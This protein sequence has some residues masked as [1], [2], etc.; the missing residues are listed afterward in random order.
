MLRLHSWEVPTN[1]PPGE[2][3][4]R[5]ESQRRQSEGQSSQHS[6]EAPREAQEP[7]GAENSDMSEAGLELAELLLQ[8]RTEGRLTA[9]DTCLIGYWASQAG[10]QGPVKELGLGPGRPTGHYQRHLDRKCGMRGQAED[11]YQIAVPAH[12]KHN[13]ERTVINV[14]VAPP[15]E[16]L[17]REYTEDPDL[18]AKAKDI[19]WPPSVLEHK[20]FKG[21]GGT[22]VPLALYVDAAEYSTQ[23]S[24]LLFVI[25]NLVS[26]ARHLACVVKKKD[27]CRCGCR[28]WCSLK[29]IMDLLNWSFSALARGMFP[30]SR[31]DG[32]PW[33]PEEEHRQS[34]ANL[35][36]SLVGAVAQVKGDWAEFSHTFGFPSWKHSEYP[37]LFCRADRDSMYAFDNLDEPGLP[38]DTIGMEEYEV[39]CRRCERHVVIRSEEQRAR[40]VEQLYYDKRAAG[41]RG[42]S[43]KAG[44][45]ELQLKAGDRLEPNTTLCD[46]ADFEQLP[47]P[48][49]VLFWRPTLETVTR[50]RNPL[51]NRDTGV[52]PESLKVDPLHCLYLGVFQIHISKVVWA[53]LD[54]DGWRVGALDDSWTE[55]ERSQMACVRMQA[56]L[57]VWCKDRRRSH[58]DEVITEV[59]EITPKMIGSRA[60]QKFGLKGGETKTFLFFIQDFLSQNARVV[61]GSAPMLAAGAAF[62]RMIQLCKD[63]GRRFTDAQQ[64]D[65]QH[66]PAKPNQTVCARTPKLRRPLM[67][68]GFPA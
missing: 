55:V 64:Q 59:Q 40:I 35:P 10:A 58:P 26:G 61:K 1:D 37:C 46:V 32:A 21:S 53:L 30:A 67:S 20:V 27:F 42:R 45:P 12:T 44:I 28:G 14:S 66:D 41:S 60:D 22:A 9:K 23:G 13:V 57:H 24:I 6:W 52:L 33:R 3:P 31:H 25:C 7:Q 68:A 16:C 50:R 39:A 18:T 43:L 4:P 34:L 62:I 49:T 65:Q 8:L 2:E 38:W 11:F 5:R 17:H 29:P 36:L 63:A 48:A 15:H 47:L 56:S 51:F 54:V 19:E